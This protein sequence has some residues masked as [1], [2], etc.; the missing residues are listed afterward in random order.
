[1][2]KKLVK[3][4]IFRQITVMEKGMSRER[5]NYT[6]HHQTTYLQPAE[7]HNRVKLDWRNS[8]IRRLDILPAFGEVGFYIIQRAYTQSSPQFPSMPL[9]GC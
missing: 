3:K 7:W 6:V 2:S 1:M 8:R 5:G 4:S 9:F